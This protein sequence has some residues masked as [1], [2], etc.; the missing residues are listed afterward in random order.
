MAK[1]HT[2]FE[3]CATAIVT[4]FKDGSIDYISLGGL[5]DFQIEKGIDALV[6]LGTTGESA[7]VSEEER[8]R[9]IAFASERINKRVPLIVGTG[10]NNTEVSIRYSKNAYRLGADALLVVTPY[11]NKATPQGLC[12]HYKKVAECVDI[13]IILYNVPSRTGVNIPISVYKELSTVDNIAAIK[14]ASSNIAYV[15][16]IM[17]TCGDKFD[18]YSG[19]DELVLPILS[20]GGKGVIS[21]VSNIIPEIMHTLCHQFKIGSIEEAR[22]IQLNLLPLIKEMFQEVNPIP[23]KTALSL[24]GMCEN[25]LRLPLCSSTR[26]EEIRKILE[27]YG[28]KT[29]IG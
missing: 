20:L 9:V 10:T 7:T 19:C 6:V 27:Q 12:Q 29:K 18:I 23:I 11:Y 26:T 1:K 4:P 28:I 22:K 25:Q 24:M 17:H 2:V 14:E 16:E 15:S 21:V 5:I 3:G 8:H 13:P